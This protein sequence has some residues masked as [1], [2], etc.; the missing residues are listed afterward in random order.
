MNNIF[1]VSLDYIQS[2]RTYIKSQ[3]TQ[4]KT[5]HQSTHQ[6]VTTRH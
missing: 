4:H 5:S 3:K 6:T 2:L 1:P